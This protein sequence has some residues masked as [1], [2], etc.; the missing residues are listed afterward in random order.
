[1]EPPAGH[2]PRAIA[3][4]ALSSVSPAE[5]CGDI[6]GIQHRQVQGAQCRIRC[7]HISPND[8]H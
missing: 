2:R 6:M 5:L 3:A 1:M 7:W 4:F 8:R